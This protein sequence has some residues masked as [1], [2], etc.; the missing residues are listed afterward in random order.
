MRLFFVEDKSHLT[1]LYCLQSTGNKIG[2]LAINIY[3]FCTKTLV[4]PAQSHLHLPK[5]LN[6]NKWELRH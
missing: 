6:V 2:V 1:M 3:K 5:R 4:D